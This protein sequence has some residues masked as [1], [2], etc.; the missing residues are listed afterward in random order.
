MLPPDRAQR[1]KKAAEKEIFL[2]RLF[3]VR[4]QMGLKQEDIRAFPQSGIQ[5]KRYK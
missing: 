3:E 5:N 4:K 1:A 2:I